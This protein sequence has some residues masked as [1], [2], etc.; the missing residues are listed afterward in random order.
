MVL[1][2][3]HGDEGSEG[4]VDASG[5]DLECHCNA[6]LTHKLRVPRSSRAHIV[7]MDQIITRTS[8]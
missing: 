4:P 1:D 7:T 2:Y 6:D 3:T 8:T 5:V